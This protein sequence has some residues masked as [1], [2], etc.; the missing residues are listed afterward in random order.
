MDEVLRAQK[1]LRIINCGNISDR[2]LKVSDG[3]MFVAYNTQRDLYEVHSI[4]SFNLNGM[5]INGV[6]EEDMLN[7]GLIESIRSSEIRRF[8]N[9]IRDERQYMEELLDNQE[10]RNENK[11]FDLGRKLMKTTL[12]R[13]V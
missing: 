5:S 10:A 9:E 13:E 6:I 8:G 3:D 2:L 11:V 1:E 12:G 7:G 4:K